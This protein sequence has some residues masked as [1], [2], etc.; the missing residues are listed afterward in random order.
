LEQQN[1]VQPNVVQKESFK[2]KTVNRPKGFGEKQKTIPQVFEYI[3]TE[4]ESKNKFVVDRTIDGIGATFRICAKSIDSLLALPRILMHIDQEVEIL[5]V[6][7]HVMMRRH[8][9]RKGI[10][11]YVKIGKKEDINRTLDI[12][13]LY[14]Q[15]LT[16]VSKGD[17]DTREPELKIQILYKENCDPKEL[18]M[19]TGD[20]EDKS[21]AVMPMTKKRSSILTIILP[22][23]GHIVN[24]NVEGI[25]YEDDDSDDEGLGVPI[26]DKHSSAALQQRKRKHQQW[27]RFKIVSV[28]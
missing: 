28:I 11:T 1:A 14:G 25:E 20:V 2:E 27:K 13:D 10:T 23:T 17:Q 16:I 21:L 7:L 5:E 22:E 9:Y 6:S 26:L 18:K 24:L 8:T 15:Q 3:R 12:G 19:L 4:F